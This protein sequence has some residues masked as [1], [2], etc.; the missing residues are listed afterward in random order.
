MRFEDVSVVTVRCADGQWVDVRLVRADGS[1]RWPDAWF[2]G[3][4][5]L[6]TLLAY[7]IYRLAMRARYVLSRST[8]WSVVVLQWPSSV[9]R[10]GNGSRV[11]A[12]WESAT[13]EAAIERA[14]AVRAALTRGERLW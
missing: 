1:K 7:G 2:V 6:V 13:R 8:T 5:G 11:L 4:L 3:K 14:E 9:S 12:R 10:S